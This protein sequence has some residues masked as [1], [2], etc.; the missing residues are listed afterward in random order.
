M[1]SGGSFLRAAT[2]GSVGLPIGLEW[3]IYQPTFGFHGAG[4]DANFGKA[5]RMTLHPRSKIRRSATVFAA[6]LLAA[7][8]AQPVPGT[9]TF[10]PTPTAVLP[11]FVY[12]QCTL[13]GAAQQTAVDLG[14]PVTVLWGWVSSTEAQMQDFIRSATITVRLDGEPLPG[15]MRGKVQFDETAKLYRAVWSAAAGILP[16][17]THTLTYQAVFSGLVSDGMATYGPGT[18]RATLSDRCEIVVR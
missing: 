18:G 12:A 5:G 15:S 13:M 11:A 1:G 8:T 9:P 2:L 17:G 4:S 3:D 16:A 7:C 10:H 14:R 6:L